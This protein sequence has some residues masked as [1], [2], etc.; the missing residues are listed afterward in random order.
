MLIFAGVALMLFFIIWCFVDN[1]RR[2]ITMGSPR[3]GGPSLILFLPVFGAL[4]YVLFRPSS[5]DENVI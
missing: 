2:Q 4:I 1:F 5:A 3:Q